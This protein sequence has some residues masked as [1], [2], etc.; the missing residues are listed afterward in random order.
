MPEQVMTV[1]GPLDPEGLGITLPHEHVLCDQSVYFRE[2]E[3]A[4]DRFLAHQPVSLENL[5]WVRYHIKDSIDCQQLLDVEMAIKELTR[6]RLAG[7]GS[8]VDMTNRSMG[9]DPAAIA[10]ISRATGLNMVIGCGHYIDATLAPRTRA[11][12]EEELAAEMVAD[13]TT[14]IGRTGVRAGVIGE[15]GCSWPITRDEKKTLRAAAMAQA[16]TGAAVNVHPNRNESGPLEAMAILTEAGA[17]PGRVVIS[18]MD[19]CGYELATRLRLLEAGAFIEY[20]C[21]GKEGY[22]PWQAAVADDHLPDMPNDVGRI[23]EIAQLIDQGFLGQILISH[24]TG[25]K[26][27]LTCWGGPGYAHIIEHVLPYMRVYG[28]TGEM[29]RSLTVD[30]P[31]RLLTRPG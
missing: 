9:Q 14:G 29:I 24:D 10:G 2:P 21:F 26:T 19:R 18:H 31:R 22:Y 8:V 7:G 20:D 5:S 15:I 13:L 27:D 6:F 1:L 4:A 11:M 23:K 25:L 3:A 17:D 28:Y 30:N 16:Q 12:T